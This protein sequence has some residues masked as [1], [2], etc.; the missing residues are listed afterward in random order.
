MLLQEMTFEI[1][2]D[3]LFALLDFMKLRGLTA[4]EEDDLQLFDGNMDVPEPK[5]MEGD[6]QYYFE[7]MH[8][9]PMKINISFVRTE[10][11]NV[12]DKYPFNR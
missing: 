9:Q 5:T 1:D 6:A 7:I 11:I 4:E 10:R 3:F 12:E 8:I 2:E